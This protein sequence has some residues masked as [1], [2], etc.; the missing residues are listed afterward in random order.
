MSFILDALK[1]S[2]QERQRQ[3][4]PSIADLPI[5]IHRT[6]TS[7]WLV[8]VVAV[9][10]LGVI[11][12]TWTWWRTSASGPVTAVATRPTPT[13]SVLAPAPRPTALETQP[14]TQAETRPETRSLASEAARMAASAS[15]RTAPQSSAERL[16]VQA[17]PAVITPSPMSIIEARASGLAV[18]ELRLELLVYSPE[19]AQRFVFINASKYVEG[20]AL[21]EGPRLIEISPEGAILSYSGQNFLLPQE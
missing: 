2:E 20:D 4:V 7:T 1:K 14:A 17:A 19:P 16:V 10:G 12:L 6:K 18:A 11:A 15:R 13:T 9:L 5:V 21:A 3:G 8:V